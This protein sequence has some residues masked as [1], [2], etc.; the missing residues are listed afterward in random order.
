METIFTRNLAFNGKQ[1]IISD[2]SGKILIFD[3]FN[4]QLEFSFSGIQDSNNKILPVEALAAYGSTIVTSHKH[5]SLIAIWEII[6]QRL[7]G[8][9]NYED[10]IDSKS[11]GVLAVNEHMIANGTIN[12]QVRIID[13]EDGSE[14]VFT[15]IDSTLSCMAIHEKQVVC[16]FT[17]GDI[18]TWNIDSRKP[19]AMFY[20]SKDIKVFRSR[21]NQIVTAI[22]IYGELIVSGHS[23]GNIHVWDMRSE[24]HTTIT[25]AHDHSVSAV[26]VNDKVICSVTSVGQTIKVRSLQSK[27]IVQKIYA[28]ADPVRDPKYAARLERLNL[29]VMP[30]LRLST[31]E[32]ICIQKD[33]KFRSILHFNLKKLNMN[34]G[35]LYYHLLTADDNEIIKNKKFT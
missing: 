14:I 32:L 19:G 21:M 2:Y 6:S 23:S 11:Q 10:D 9:Y 7:N 1:V 5:S 26:A 8:T 20:E 3:A 30:I 29:M 17:N 33:N 25:N 28:V 12:K 13:R 22:D 34:P 27:K 4:N 31:D 18:A 35:F 24:I 15:H 16:G